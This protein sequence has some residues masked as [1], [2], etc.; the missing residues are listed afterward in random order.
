M[1]KTNRYKQLMMRYNRL[2]GYPVV[3]VGLKKESGCHQGG[4]N[5]HNVEVDN[6]LELVSSRAK[7]CYL[8]NQS[9]CY[10]LAK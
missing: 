1:N 2:E 6:F 4:S 8:E 3:F 5:A 7:R 9:F 10:W